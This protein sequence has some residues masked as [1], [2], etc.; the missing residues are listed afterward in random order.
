M[1]F[2]HS[3]AADFDAPP[4]TEIVLH[5]HNNEGLDDNDVNELPFGNDFEDQAPI[6]RGT[7]FFG[8][9]RNKLIITGMTA[10]V[11]LFVSCTSIAVSRNNRIAS[12]FA[13][14]D[15]CKASKLQAPKQSKSPKQ[16]KAL[17]KSK[18][19]KQ[20]GTPAPGTP[21]SLNPSS[22]I[23]P[24]E[25]PSPTPSEVPSVSSE[26]SL[27]PSSNP[28]VTVSIDP[29]FEPSGVPSVSSEPSLDPSSNPTVSIDP[30]FEPSG[31]PSVSS[32][33]SMDRQLYALSVLYDATNGDSWDNKSGWLDFSQSECDWYGVT[34]NDENIVTK[35]ELGSNNLIGSIPTQIGLLKS[36]EKLILSENRELTGTIPSEIEHLSLFA[37]ALIGPIPSEVCALRDNK[38][39]KL[40]ANC[41]IVSFCRVLWTTHGKKHGFPTPISSQSQRQVVIICTERFEQRGDS[42]TS[43]GTPTGAE[44][45]TSSRRTNQSKSADIC[46]C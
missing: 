28:T 33:P 5:I 17:K 31:V 3:N 34:C 9:N 8:R 26:P 46:R 19:P 42:G 16:S 1:N 10:A 39:D 32:E 21:P 4:G 14:V 24:S 13:T 45:E 40:F 36:L 23:N 20:S 29:S 43:L 27:D 12:N 6:H 30:S 7:S 25:M 38:L 15:A 37:N 22:S 11:V 35:L 41:S 18:A 44:P 2:N